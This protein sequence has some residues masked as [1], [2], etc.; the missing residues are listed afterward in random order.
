[1]CDLL[2][3]FNAGAYHAARLSLTP[4]STALSSA[5][6]WAYA[7]RTPEGHDGVTHTLAIYGL[8][9]SATARRSRSA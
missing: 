2:P 3:G 9:E 8:D 4:Q 6:T 7:L 5:G 1:M